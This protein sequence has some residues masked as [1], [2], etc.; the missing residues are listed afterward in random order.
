MRCIHNPQ[1]ARAHRDIVADAD[2]RI[3]DVTSMQHTR[4][5]RP[6]S[7]FGAIPIDRDRNT[8]HLAPENAQYPSTHIG[9]QG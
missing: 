4:N 1:A 3:G 5:Q 9:R 7:R 8:A 6:D 2:E